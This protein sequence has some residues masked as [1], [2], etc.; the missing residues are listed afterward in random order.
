MNERDCSI[1]HSTLAQIDR[2]VAGELSEAERCSLLAWLDEDARRWRT[3]AIAF[4]EAQS[5]EDAAGD[6]TLA[7]SAT[8]ARSASEG[9]VP[10]FESMPSRRKTTHLHAVAVAASIALAFAAG[11]LAARHVPERK[12]KQDVNSVNIAHQPDV[13][14]APDQPVVA[15]VSVRTNLDPDVPAQLQLPVTPTSA[16]QSAASSLSEYEREQWERSGFEVREERRY[17]PARLPDG[18]EVIVPVN[19]VQL[20]LKPATMS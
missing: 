3:C 16:A 15:T 4:L 7:R 19:K 20:K 17:L 6:L 9:K 11:I 10:S 8:P 14:R 13:P 5:W 12:A 18:R 1:D 2:L